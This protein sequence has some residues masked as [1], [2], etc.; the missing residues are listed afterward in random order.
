MSL[1]EL[2]PILLV[3]DND[4]TRSTK[5]E[6][7]ILYNQV[8]LNASLISHLNKVDK[9]IYPTACYNNSPSSFDSRVNLYW[10]D[11]SSNIIDQLPWQATGFQNCTQYSNL[12]RLIIV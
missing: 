9:F 12:G 5:L 8:S 11:L 3:T 4:A 10:I 2:L 1:P 6:K 7:H